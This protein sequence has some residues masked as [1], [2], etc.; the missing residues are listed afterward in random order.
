MTATD[1]DRTGSW[2]ATDRESGGRFRIIR[3]H[4][5]GG[6]GS[7]FLAHDG[8]VN[9]EVALKQLKEE[10]ASRSPESGAGSSSRR[11]SPATSSIRESCLSTARAST[12]DGRP[13]YAMRFIRGDNLKVAVDR[14]HNNPALKSDAG[15]RQREFQKLLRRFLVVCETM[16]YVHSRGVIHRDL[17]TAQYPARAVRRD[18]GRR[19]GAGQGGR[20]CRK[21]IGL[22]RDHTTAF[23]QR[24]SADHGRLAGWHPGLYEP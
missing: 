22:R 24:Y 21:R 20:S 2:G 1:P 8:E 7:V 4:D 19:L 17:E 15:A 13:Y 10:I 14:F 5:E 6:L 16:S 18:A 9:R 3:L 11:R 23:Q 12:A